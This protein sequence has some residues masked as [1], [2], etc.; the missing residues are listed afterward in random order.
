LSQC[1]RRSNDIYLSMSTFP[2]SHTLNM[3]LQELW[4]NS[5]MSSK[6]SVKRHGRLPKPES[7]TCMVWFL[8]NRCGAYQ[9]SVYSH[10]VVSYVTVFDA[11]QISQWVT[12]KNN[13][14]QR[15]PMGELRVQYKSSLAWYGSRVWTK[16]A[17]GQTQ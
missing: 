3:T 4:R 13:H 9:V 14:L 8:Q 16:Q 2:G 7:P 10:S 17:R 5:A 1:W 11:D 6:S 15:L 12:S